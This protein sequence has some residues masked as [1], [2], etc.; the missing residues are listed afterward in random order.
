[1]VFLGFHSPVLGQQLLPKVP[2]KC[3]KPSASQQALRTFLFPACQRSCRK[4]FFV[5]N[6]IHENIMTRNNKT[7]KFYYTKISRYTVCL[8]RLY[9]GMNI[10]C[11][12]SNFGE[13]N[14]AQL[15]RNRMRHV[16]RVKLSKSTLRIQRHAV[17]GGPHQFYTQARVPLTLCAACRGSPTIELHGL[18]ALTTGLR[19]V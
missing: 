1:M 9:F 14:G 19:T 18:Y 12:E 10:S 6:P 5:G 8:T 11:S 4:K 13:L 3:G 7:R 15:E 2:D 17:G 16:G